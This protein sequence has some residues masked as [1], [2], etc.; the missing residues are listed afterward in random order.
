MLNVKLLPSHI[1]NKPPTEIL[2]ANGLG[3]NLAAAE[4]I[5]PHALETIHLYWKLFAVTGAAD[6]LKVAVVNP[7]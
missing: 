5:F 6:K 3:F 2:G 4:V 1:F 7:E